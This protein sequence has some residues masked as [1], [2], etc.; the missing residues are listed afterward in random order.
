MSHRNTSGKTKVARGQAHEEAETAWKHGLGFDPERD[1][2]RIGPR[3]AQT[4]YGNNDR[5]DHEGYSTSDALYGAF[6]KRMQNCAYISCSS[7]SLSRWPLIIKPNGSTTSP[8]W[9]QVFAG[10]C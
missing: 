7:P 8:F 6:L 10:S 5:R 2:T 3:H 1:Q 9:F 4:A